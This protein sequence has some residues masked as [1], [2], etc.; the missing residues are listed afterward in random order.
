[1][2]FKLFDWLFVTSVPSPP[3]NISISRECPFPWQLSWTRSEPDEWNLTS[4]EVAQ[5]SSY[6]TEV[7][8]SVEVVDQ[9]QLVFQV[10]LFSLNGSEEY[11]FEVRSVG[12]DGAGNYSEAVHYRAQLCGEWE[13]LE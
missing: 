11:W 10:S 4:F 3:S 7:V 1:M 9:E 6:S 8:R 12:L 2:F 13:V 5:Q